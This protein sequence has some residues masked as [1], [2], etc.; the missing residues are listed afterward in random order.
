MKY[1][2][3]DFK[4]KNTPFAYNDFIAI[5]N[6]FKWN[7]NFKTIYVTGTN[8]K[9]S[10]CKYIHDELVANGYKVGAFTSP[11]IMNVN[12]RIII[13]G[14]PI[15]NRKMDKLHKRLKVSFPT[16]N[17]GWF[18]MLFFI[19][20]MYFHQKKV[21]VAIFEAGIGAKKDITNFINH[22][23]SIIT[24]IGIDHQDV[25]GNSIKEI[26]EDKSYAI[27]EGRITYITD[28]ISDDVLDIFISKSK[29]FNTKLNIVKT[30]K[31]TYKTIN[32]SISKT[33]LKNE[34]KI[35]D[36]KSNF[37]S[38]NGRMES[39][40]INK[41]K[42]YLDVSHNVQAFKKTFEYIKEKNI[43]I[44]QIVLSLSKDKDYNEIFNLLKQFKLQIYCYQNNGLKPLEIEK[45][46]NNFVRISDLKSFLKK[47]NKPTLFIG[48]FYF[49]NDILKI[50]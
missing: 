36:F 47:I 6:F 29:L 32:E 12:E 17:F 3:I 11:H 18:D 40:Y 50:I 19:A 24:S 35:K 33:F 49:V 45:Y 5:G 14:K 44:D 1:N 9:G 7:F 30:D 22:D 20:I 48:S 4:K 34:F 38:P 2:K 15:S 25:L 27:K 26:A 16:F 31:T 10:N 37:T 42:C 28:D 41:N 39:F 43:I 21:D 23:Y 13:N 8:G 46:D